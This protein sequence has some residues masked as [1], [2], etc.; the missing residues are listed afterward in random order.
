MDAPWE[1]VFLLGI[2]RQ[3]CWVPKVSY[4][5]EGLVSAVSKWITNSPW[6][7]WESIYEYRVF[8]TW[9]IVE[10]FDYIWYGFNCLMVLGQMIEVLISFDFQ[11]AGRWREGL[12]SGGVLVSAWLMWRANSRHGRHT[13]VM[14]NMQCTRL[15]ELFPMLVS[16]FYW[17]DDLLFVDDF[18]L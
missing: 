3:L 10:S 15:V 1:L 18:E 13:R 4:P 11:P 2:R 16:L 17:R 9:F 8:W 14:W 7:A 12:M 6:S 5:W